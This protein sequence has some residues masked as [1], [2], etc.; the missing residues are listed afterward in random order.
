MADIAHS[1]STSR[2]TM[3]RGLA[4]LPLATSG[5]VALTVDPI[6]AAIERHRV[7]STI[8]NASGITDD[9]RDVLAVHEMDMQY[10][11]HETEPTTLAGLKAYVL[12]WSEFY[13]RCPLVEDAGMALPN[14][15]AAM[16][17]LL[18]A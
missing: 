5:A 14:I 4:T 12:Y 13:W 9:E 10:E 16:R 1:T 17:T 2:R 18:P 15:A 11:L 6:F 3:L 7:A 8:A